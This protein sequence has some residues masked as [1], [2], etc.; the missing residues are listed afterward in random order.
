MPAAIESIQERSPSPASQ[1][2]KKSEKSTKTGLS[3]PHVYV[4]PPE[5][6]EL[7]NQ[8]WCYFDAVKDAQ[9]GAFANEDDFH[10][11]IDQSPHAASIY[12]YN[13]LRGGTKR[14]NIYTM[15]SLVEE[16]RTL[17]EQLRTLELSSGTPQFPVLPILHESLEENS[18]KHGNTAQSNSPRGRSLLTLVKRKRSFKAKPSPA[19]SGSDNDPLETARPSVEDR[20]FDIAHQRDANATQLD[21]QLA[22][23]PSFFAR[24]FKI[25]PKKTTDSG[26]KR[27]LNRM[28]PSLDTKRSYETLGAS[29]LSQDQ[30]VSRRFSFFELSRRFST[31]SQTTLPSVEPST[32][33][34]NSSLATS[35]ASPATPGGDNS[36][37]M[38]PPDS[39][40]EKF[41]PAAAITSLDTSIENL[42]ASLRLPSSYGSG[43]GPAFS[44]DPLHF[45]SLEFNSDDF[46]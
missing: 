41:V 45:E 10:D 5:E 37:F 13:G 32:N 39:P 20:G 46:P 38:S 36:G 1:E 14:E 27:P 22:R 44:L 40:F 18:A 33:H 21:S 7:D 34:S 3:L 30:K 19:S 12:A 25:S 2:S 17:R 42:A 8:T 24:R 35:S 43:N 6:D 16:A 15:N 29:R 26:N 23:K 28:K 9:P 4:T 11:T 31:S